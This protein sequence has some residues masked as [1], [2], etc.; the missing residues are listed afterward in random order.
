MGFGEPREVASRFND[1]ALHAETNAEE[2]HVAL[3]GPADR[4][5]LALESALAEA[6]GNQESVDTFEQRGA[7]RGEVLGADFSQLDLNVFGDSHVC[8][9]FVD[10][11][12]GVVELDVLTGDG[13]R[14][15]VL[16]DGPIGG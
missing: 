16:G 11:L 3:A 2:R 10:R 6:S 8:E 14:D 5:N 4:G 1:G 7:L 9:R 15:L 12:V 13:D